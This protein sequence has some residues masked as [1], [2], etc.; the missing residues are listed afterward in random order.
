MP[1]GK[2]LRFPSASKPT[3]TTKAKAPMRPIDWAIVAFLNR[4]E[5]ELG[6]I[7]A[8]R[9][10]S[11]HEKDLRERIAAGDIRDGLGATKGVG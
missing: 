6:T 2:L 11:V 8:A 3:P 9:V 7:A 1:P 4:L 5:S 10:L